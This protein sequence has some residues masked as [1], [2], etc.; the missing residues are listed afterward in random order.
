[1]KGFIFSIEAIFAASLLI[2][3]I[4]A[5]SF[6]AEQEIS[7]SFIDEVIVRGS[8]SLYF[9]E[10]ITN[11]EKENNYCINFIEFD[12]GIKNKIIC[13]GYNE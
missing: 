4:F 12:E 1:M 9:N 7:H 8:N 2:I 10:N 6:V 5:I 13:E 3:G 11:N